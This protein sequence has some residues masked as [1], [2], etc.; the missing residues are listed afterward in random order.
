[1]RRTLP[2]DLDQP[3]PP[4][5]RVL[6]MGAAFVVCPAGWQSKIEMLEAAGYETAMVWSIKR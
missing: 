5:V 4:T 2:R 1:M 6:K 3:L